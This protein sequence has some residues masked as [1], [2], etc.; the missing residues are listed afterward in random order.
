MVM[1][2][3]MMMDKMMMTMMMMMLVKQFVVYRKWRSNVLYATFNTDASSR[4]TQPLRT[5]FFVSELFSL[6]NF[7]FFLLLIQV[8]WH[9]CVGGKGMSLFCFFLYSEFKLLKIFCRFFFLSLFFFYCYLF[10]FIHPSFRS[11]THSFILVQ[12]LE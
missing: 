7:V 5:T 8:F 2:M 6:I 1:M 11:F 4:G 3:T 10:S 12:P 9:L